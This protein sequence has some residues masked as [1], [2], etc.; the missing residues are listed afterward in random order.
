MV[1]VIRGRDTVYIGGR[2]FSVAPEEQERFISEEVARQSG[3]LTPAQR[4]LQEAAQRRAEAA[5]QAEQA[6]KEAAEISKQEEKPTTA[7]LLASSDVQIAEPKTGLAKLQESISVAR[8]RRTTPPIAQPFLG[9]G[10][11]IIS[12]AQ[13][14]TQLFKRPVETTKEVGKG[15]F[16]EAKTFFTT[17]TSPTLAR[18][19]AVARQEPLFATGFLAGEAITAKGVGLAGKAGAK[20]VRVGATR[21][22]PRFVPVTDDVLKVGTTVGETEIKV[23]GG[24]AS[25]A[26]PLRTQAQLAGKEVTAVSA[27]RGLFGRFTKEIVVDKPL[28]TPTSPE[29]ERSFFADPR[30]RVRTSRLGIE[31]RPE[32]GLKDIL[33]GDVSIRREKPQILVFPEQKVAQFPSRLKGVEAKLKAGKTLTAVEE[34]ELLKFQLEPSGE[35]KPVGFLSR[36]SEITAAPKE[37]I[38]RERRIGTT[39][40]KGEPVEI[41]EARLRKGTGIAEDV[42]DFGRVRGRKTVS[43]LE[44]VSRPKISP[45]RAVSAIPSP[46]FAISPRAISGGVS[47]R[48]APRGVSPIGTSG[49]VDPVGISPRAISGGASPIGGTFGLSPALGTPTITPPARSRRPRL[50]MDDDT[51][52]RFKTLK[53]TERKTKVVS[54]AF[55]AGF[56]VTGE[57]TKG[58]ITSGLGVRPVKKIKR[59]NK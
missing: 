39:L 12:S 50:R 9:L 37:V 52:R 32:A 55:A 34:A 40:I 51:F 21:V 58:Q 36:E 44:P 22:S 13:F 41:I 57:I 7:Q 3:G 53:P 14:G 10:A 5:R 59:R 49:V 56:G 54:T 38:A 47:P 25:T 23:A 6:R 8:Q 28:P 1:S 35:F 11:S 43:S 29:L 45:S 17:G 48:V 19:V 33:A 4:Q 26:E 18:G 20:V 2:G 27:Q 42:S 24:V 16:R 46:R 15:T 30:G 31:E